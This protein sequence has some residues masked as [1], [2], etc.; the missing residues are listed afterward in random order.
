M[1]SLLLIAEVL[2]DR[3]GGQEQREGIERDIA[4]AASGCASPFVLLTHER[5]LG[6]GRSATAYYT[7]APCIR[8][9]FRESTAFPPLAELPLD[10]ALSLPRL[11]RQGMQRVRDYVH[12]A[13]MTHHLLVWGTEDPTGTHPLFATHR[14]NTQL[15]L[16][17][18]D[19]ELARCGAQRCSPQDLRH[20][21]SRS[22]QRQLDT[23]RDRREIR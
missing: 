19:A 22:L 10:P 12:G 14:G 8:E 9:R 18:T 13:S 17:M 23:S 15:L 11:V 4:A 1:Q 16:R 7:S 5:E 3:D 20:F 21:I 6:D 2:N